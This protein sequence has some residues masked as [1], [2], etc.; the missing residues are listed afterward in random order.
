MAMTVA[1]GTTVS[2]APVAV[3][4]A[5]AGT[6]AT[7]IIDGAHPGPE[8]QGIGAISGGGRAAEAAGVAPASSL[9]PSAPPVPARRPRQPRRCHIAVVRTTTE[10]H[11]RGSAQGEAVRADGGLGGGGGLPN[12][13][14]P[15]FQCVRTHWIRGFMA[16]RRAPAH[17][18][19]EADGAGG[20]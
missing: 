11:R 19:R 6:G 12:S 4:A 18:E 13:M 15:G 20:T 8:F 10:S 14:D 16:F 7:V 17:P 9:T 5:G 1:L 3:P 2:A